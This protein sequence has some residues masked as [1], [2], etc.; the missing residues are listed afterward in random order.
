MTSGERFAEAYRAFLA[1][2]MPY[3]EHYDFSISAARAAAIRARLNN[4]ARNGAPELCAK[5]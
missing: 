4:A 1:G 3:P 2:K 5:S